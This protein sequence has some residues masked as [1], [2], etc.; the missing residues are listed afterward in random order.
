MTEKLESIY[1]LIEEYRQ[2]SKIEKK[3]YGEVFS[4]FELI[5]EMLDTLPSEVWSDPKLKWL[6]PANGIGNFPLIIV[7][8][9]MKGL[10]EWQPD[11]EKRYKHIIE[12]MIYVCDI[13]P[14]NNFIFIQLFGGIGK[15]EY[16]PNLCTT[17][18]LNNGF[19]TW[20]KDKNIKKFDIIVGNFPYN[21][22]S[23][24]KSRLGSFPLWIKFINK[25]FTMLKENGYLVT[26]HPSLWR[27]ANDKKCSILREKNIIHLSINDEK[28]GMKT[29]GAETRY[30]WYLLQNAKYKGNTTVSDQENQTF[31]IDLS[32]WEFIPNMMFDEIEKLLPKGEEDSVKILYSRSMYGTD[33]KN[34]SKEKVGNFKYP[35]IYMISKEGEFKFFYSNIKKEHFNETKVMV[36]PGRISS[37]NVVGD[38]NGDYG[39]CQFAWGVKCNKTDIDDIVEYM[40]GEEF[41]KIAYACSV[42]KLEYNK[43]IIGCFKKEF[44]K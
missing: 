33:K 6:D 20:I 26:V 41:K 13:Q 25:I 29:F 23:K 38:K 12:K 22:K 16:K 39:L 14:K 4:P 34:M 27:Q 7:I 19:N 9:L 18:F 43:N 10:K 2:I 5:N 36:P 21:D 31:D 11:E 3:E 44:W 35:C 32:N 15:E 28:K 1:H 37:V 42:S 17:S 24:G 40:N 8:R 30:D